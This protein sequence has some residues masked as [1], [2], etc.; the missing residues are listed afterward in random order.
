MNTSQLTPPPADGSKES[1]R[2]CDGTGHDDH[3]IRCHDC[4]GS[5]VLGDGLLQCLAS[6]SRGLEVECPTCAAAVGIDCARGVAEPDQAP[7][8]D[9]DTFE[10]IELMHTRRLRVAVATLA[11]RPERLAA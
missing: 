5:G 10:V 3:E 7:V 2:L 1:C 4:F 9:G 11:Q 8:V 6:T